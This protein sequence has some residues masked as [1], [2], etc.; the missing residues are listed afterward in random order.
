MHTDDLI[1][2]K[3]KN[4]CRKIQLTTQHACNFTGARVHTHTHTHTHTHRG[5][6][7]SIKIVFSPLATISVLKYI[8]FRCIKHQREVAR[9]GIGERE[10]K[11]AGKE[12]RKTKTKA[13][14]L[15]LPMNW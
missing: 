14:A 11:I 3:H 15:G 13:K 1:S 7:A 4:I 6:R 12:D 2:Y 10:G 9:V 5:V 8:F